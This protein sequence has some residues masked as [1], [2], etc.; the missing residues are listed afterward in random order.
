MLFLQVRCSHKS[1]RIR[2]VG[3]IIQTA[4][5]KVL[6]VLARR[7]RSG[8]VHMVLIGKALAKELAVV[9]S[10]QIWPVHETLCSLSIR[11]GMTGGLQLESAQLMAMPCKTYFSFT[12][13][14]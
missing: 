2:H 4:E 3:I 12:N 1:S 9:N 14:F 13:P 6:E 5:E 8:Q 10:C 7:M 11:I